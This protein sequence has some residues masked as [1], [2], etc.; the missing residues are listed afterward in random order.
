MPEG[1]KSLWPDID[2]NKKLEL[3]ER[4]VMAGTNSEA[5]TIPQNEQGIEGKGMIRLAMRGRNSTRMR[6][7]SSMNRL[8]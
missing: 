4:Q 6:L 2:L 3:T 5:G 1:S 8:R 7:S